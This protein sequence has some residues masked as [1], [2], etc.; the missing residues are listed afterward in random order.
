[1]EPSLRQLPKLTSHPSD[2]TSFSSTPSNFEDYYSVKQA[3]E[4]RLEAYSPKPN[5]D[6]TVDFLRVV[7]EYLP[8]RG[9]QNLMWDISSLENDEDLRILRLHL[10]DCLLAP[11]KH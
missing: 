8:K 3:T 4:R 5:E 1:M 2:S 6:D 11:S 9:A 7:M 10:I